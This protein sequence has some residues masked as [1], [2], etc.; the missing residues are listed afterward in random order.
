M[1]YPDQGHTVVLG[2]AGSGKTTLAILRARYLST[3]ALNRGRT[4][5]VTFNRML[6]TYLRTVDREAVRGV[7]VRNYHDFARGFLG[8]R[9]RLPP[10]GGI[11]RPDLRLRLIGQALEITRTRYPNARIFQHS[12]EAHAEELAWIQR[13]GIASAG[14]YA[15]AERIHRG[16]FRVAGRDRGYI[17]EI[18][19]EYLRLRERWGVLYDWEDIAAAVLEAFSR[20]NTPR[21]YRHIVIDEGQDFS[22]V[23]LRSLAAAVPREGSVTF[24]GDMA[25]QIYGSRISW[26]DAGLHVPRGV[27][28]FRENYRNTKQIADFALALA[29]GPY[30]TGVPDMVA[31]SAPRAAGIPPTLVRCSNQAAEIR[32]V[33]SQAAALG[34]T[35]SVGILLR[36]RSRE[37]VY[38]E[39]LAGQGVKVQRLHRNTLSWHNAPGVWV[40]TYY[41]GKGLEFDA[42]LL[43]HVEASTIPDP[44]RV[45]A[46]GDERL[47][48]AEEARLLYVAITRARASLV[49]T[50]HGELTPLLREIDP[51]L[52]RHE[53]V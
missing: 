32:F 3:D 42:V 46:L 23:M 22:P 35:R 28:E 13:M 33:V 45:V 37:K 50:Y 6:A 48:F 4:M 30:F 43:P 49:L 18:Y 11:A 51:A 9:A 8:A 31:P 24:F 41:S 17:W 15:G 2:T 52:Y 5:L 7:E 25:Q 1:Y 53:V 47:A 34:R 44:E 39:R 14:A 20:D 36:D 26:R 38:L 29:S 27:V 16:G 10:S 40:G 21:R 12:P 19:E